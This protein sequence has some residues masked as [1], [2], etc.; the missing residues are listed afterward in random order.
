MD[1]ILGQL[2]Y[3]SLAGVG[4]KTLASDRVPKEIQK[5]FCESFVPR[6]W[7]SYNPPPSGYRAVYLHQIAPEHTLFGWLYNDGVDD[8]G[9]GDVP[10][11]ICYYQAEPLLDFHLKNIFT[12]LQKGPLALIDRHSPPA[13]L[14]TRVVP[15]LWSY[16]PARPGVVLPSVVRARSRI[17]LKQE[18]LLDLFIPVDQQQTIVTLDGQTYEQQMAKLSIYNRY[19]IESIKVVKTGAMAL[20][21]QNAAVIEFEDVKTHP[22]AEKQLVWESLDWH[23]PNFRLP[24]ESAAAIKSQ[25]AT[26]VKALAIH[27][28]NTSSPVVE[29]KLPQILATFNTVSQQSVEDRCVV[30]YKNSQLLLKIGITATVLALF[31]SIYGIVVTIFFHPSHRE[32]SPSPIRGTKEQGV[33]QTSWINPEV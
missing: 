16:Q 15:D 19:L 2:V 6:Y 10:Y 18:K 23:K 22:T 31:G 14:E 33:G 24:A 27:E 4:F 8:L 12:C 32:F 9:R 26:A 17:A 28:A 30:G 11:F 13:S 21:E 20:S 7:N 1:L 29:T 25:E 3:T 5:A